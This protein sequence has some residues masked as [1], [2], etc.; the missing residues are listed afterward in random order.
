MPPAVGDCVCR[1]D[2]RRKDL[3][4]PLRGLPSY[5]GVSF[6]VVSR[7]NIHSCYRG[8]ILGVTQVGQTLWNPA[9]P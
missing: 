7:R 9:L 8:D 4:A 2:L 6:S 3:Q 1:R 5:Q